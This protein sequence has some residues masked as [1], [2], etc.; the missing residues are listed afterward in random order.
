MRTPHAT[1][2]REPRARK[3]RSEL[4]LVLVRGAAVLGKQEASEGVTSYLSKLMSDIS[5]AFQLSL[6]GKE[7]ELASMLKARMI[8]VAACQTTGMYS[9]WS[10]L[11]AAAS[12]G[13]TQ[14][15]QMLLDAGAP[16][17]A[18][19]PQSKTPAQVAHEKE[20]FAVAALLQQ[21]EASSPAPKPPVL[22]PDEPLRGYWQN[23]PPCDCGQPRKVVDG[24]HVCRYFGHYECDC[25]GRRWKS[26]WCWRDLAVTSGWSRLHLGHESPVAPACLPQK[27]QTCETDTWPYQTDQLNGDGRLHVGAAVRV[28]SA[29]DLETS[30]YVGLEGRIVDQD[31]QSERPFKVKFDDGQELWFRESELERVPVPHDSIRCSM[32]QRLGSDCSRKRVI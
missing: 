7:A 5:S 8:D 23:A 1:F 14:I 30:P 17:S 29:S 6:N 22:V 16:A 31:D 19:N 27:C 2:L 13:H 32:C 11:H 4:T 25:C 9:G 20:Y 18:C 3:T 26:P 28:L 12:K 10:L 15:V 21:A 24:I